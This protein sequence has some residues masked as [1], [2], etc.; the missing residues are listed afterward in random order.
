MLFLFGRVRVR[1]FALSALLFGAVAAG[2][3]A[4]LGSV[5]VSS[6]IENAD[7]L[8]S[9]IPGGPAAAGVRLGVRLHHA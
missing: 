1:R 8:Q 7:K 3:R 6:V 4:F 9:D 2:R 5:V